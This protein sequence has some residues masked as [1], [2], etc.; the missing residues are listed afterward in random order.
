[1][2]QSWADFAAWRATVSE[3]RWA[4]EDEWQLGFARFAR[5]R[6]RRYG[7]PAA[8]LMAYDFGFPDYPGAPLSMNGP[9]RAVR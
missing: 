1:M 8:D 5:V 2:A 4:D 9:C 7:L 3:S 6:L